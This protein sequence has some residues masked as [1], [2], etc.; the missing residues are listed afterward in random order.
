MPSKD[1]AFGF[2]LP[3]AMN[4]SFAASFSKA[5]REVDELRQYLDKLGR[6]QTA[7]ESFRRWHHQQEDV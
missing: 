6:K 5:S 3:A 7:A 4:S 2:V 1:F